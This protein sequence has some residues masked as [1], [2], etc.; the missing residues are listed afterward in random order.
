MDVSRT[1]VDGRG[2]ARLVGTAP[3]FGDADGDRR[4]ERRIRR[5]TRV[6]TRR[7]PTVLPAVRSQ[8][9]SGRRP[10][11]TNPRQLSFVLACLFAIAPAL[12][13]V[14]AQPASLPNKPDSVKF[15][16]IG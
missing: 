14:V 15:A 12:P 5:E 4:R 7:A 1:R 11:K 9:G 13:V 6:G 2:R 16:A 8:G 3:C 10:V